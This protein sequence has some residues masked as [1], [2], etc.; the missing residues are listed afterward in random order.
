MSIIHSLFSG[1]L[2]ISFF[3]I[4]IVAIYYLC[5]VIVY[6]AAFIYALIA[7]AIEKSSGK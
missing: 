1:I 6:A 2:P 3:M 4:N 7:S 5:K